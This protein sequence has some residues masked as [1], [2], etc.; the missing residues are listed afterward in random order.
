MT[1]TDN[2]EKLFRA[3]YR[4][5]C[6]YALHILGDIDTAEDIV[7]EQFVKLAE[8]KYKTNNLLSPKSY[9]YQMTRNASIDYIKRHIQA[10]TTEELPEIL[11]T[12][13][14]SQERCEREARLWEQIDTLPPSCRK[15]LLMSKRDGM[16]YREI[17]DALNISIKTVEAQMG[18]AY[19]TLRGKAKEIYT[20]FFL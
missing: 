20:F 18:K 9:L 16:K 17:A 14:E 8:S 19:A 11:D 10:N 4:A 12:C 15:I 2:I 6:L 3:H 1:H 5:L 13:T 7:M